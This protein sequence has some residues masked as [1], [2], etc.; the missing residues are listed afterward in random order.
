MI[1]SQLHTQSR[2]SLCCLTGP[3]AYP[4]H[5]HAFGEIF[6]VESGPFTHLVNGAE[7]SLTEGSCIFIRPW[8]QH[9][10]QTP[11]P[12]QIEIFNICFQWP[13]Y[14]YL[15]HRY[16]PHLDLYGE[17]ASLPKTLQ[18]LSSQAKGLRN[19]VPSLA[20]RPDSIFEVE[21]FLI[22]LFAEL[23]PPDE[24]PASTQLP[25]PWME[26][27]MLAIRRPESLRLGVQE[28]YR[29]CGRSR[30]HVSREF[31][32]VTGITIVQWLNQLRMEHAAG[33]LAA[34]QKEIIDISLDCGYESLSHFY[35]SFRKH[36]GLAPLG[37]R[38]KAQGQLYPDNVCS[39]RSAK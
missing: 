3:V 20:K 27:A 31:H 9:A 8:D 34:T 4:L 24:L 11:G 19:A 32:R 23:S 35:A 1:R 29:L 14:R 16:F 17:Q 7:I 39:S 33:L 26:Q 12:E 38:R 28:F 21:R 15:R 5:D 6:W 36:F 25:P 13:I 10:F 37:Y 18:L 30:E 2:A 22:N